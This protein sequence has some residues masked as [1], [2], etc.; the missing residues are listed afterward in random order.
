MLLSDVGAGFGC[1][2]SN[3]LRTRLRLGREVELLQ[4]HLLPFPGH[5]GTEKAIL[6]LKDGETE[7]RHHLTHLS[8]TFQSQTIPT[9]VPAPAQPPPAPGSFLWSEI[10]SALPWVA[11]DPPQT[12]PRSGARGLA[13]GA[14]GGAQDTRWHCVTEHGTR[15]PAGN[16]GSISPPGDRGMREIPLQPELMGLQTLSV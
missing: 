11:A 4:Q 8:R 15:R 10:A 2:T 7:A 16:S 12:P 1:P 5:L 6:V 13:A 3:Q 9:A 14:P